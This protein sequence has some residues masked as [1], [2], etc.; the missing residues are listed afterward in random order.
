MPSAN[1]ELCSPRNELQEKSETFSPMWSGY[2]LATVMT[3]T[4]KLTSQCG[5]HK[6]QSSGYCHLV[7]F[8]E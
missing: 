4:C 2:P 1:F 7:I 5:Q 8:I 3:R 6:V